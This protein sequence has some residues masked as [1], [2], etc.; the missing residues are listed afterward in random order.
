MTGPQWLFVVVYRWNWA[1]AV[2]AGM[3]RRVPAGTENGEVAED[4]ISTRYAALK[5]HRALPVARP[6]ANANEMKLTDS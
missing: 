3:F 5:K 2:L 4:R 6:V 1:I